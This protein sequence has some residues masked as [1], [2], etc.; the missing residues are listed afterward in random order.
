MPTFETEKTPSAQRDD[1]LFL[2]L[3]Q[4]KKACFTVYAAVVVT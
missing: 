2:S 1:E 3:L 4:L